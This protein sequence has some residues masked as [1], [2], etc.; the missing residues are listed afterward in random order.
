VG[1]IRNSDAA[2]FLRAIAQSKSVDGTTV[3]AGLLVVD[4]E[5][6][7]SNLDCSQTRPQQRQQLVPAE[8]PAEAGMA[9]TPCR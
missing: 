1:G 6:V 5:F 9:W 4:V 2:R 8:E 3:R 7:A